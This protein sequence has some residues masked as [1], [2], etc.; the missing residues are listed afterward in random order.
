MTKEIGCQNKSTK[1]GALFRKRMQKKG[2]DWL[3]HWVPKEFK[4]KVKEFAKGLRDKG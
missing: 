3:C 2:Y 4:E 1:R